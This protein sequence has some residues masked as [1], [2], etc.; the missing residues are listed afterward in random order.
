LP[1]GQS[2]LLAPPIGTLPP[3]HRNRDRARPAAGIRELSALV[4]TSAIATG[5]GELACDAEMTLRESRA[6]CLNL[7]WGL[8]QNV[9]GPGS[10]GPASLHARIGDRVG[11][12]NQPEARTG[13]RILPRS[14]R[15][16]MAYKQSDTPPVLARGAKNSSAMLS[17]SRN[18]NAE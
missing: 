17:G 8:A 5:D 7:D 4:G 15:Y 11:L 3:G 18:D 12:P 6:G 9:S 10:R 1:R 2:R 16:G 14:R 13:R